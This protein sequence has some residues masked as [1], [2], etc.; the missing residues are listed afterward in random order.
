M[1]YFELPGF[2]LSGVMVY[3]Q[4]SGSWVRRQV[5]SSLCLSAI[6]KITVP[7]SAATTVLE[8]RG[9]YRLSSTVNRLPSAVFRHTVAAWPVPVRAGDGAG[10]P[11]PVLRR[12]RPGPG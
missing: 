4:E 8:N 6:R 1:D 7:S 2:N 11:V 3:I 10:M 9:S 12:P 5:P